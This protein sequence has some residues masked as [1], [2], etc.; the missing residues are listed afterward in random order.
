MCV[1]VCVGKR[2]EGGGGEALLSNKRR[3]QIESTGK[4]K[5]QAQEIGILRW[6]PQR[7]CPRSLCPIEN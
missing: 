3:K 2:E 6:K 1:C 4:E 5:K 7:A